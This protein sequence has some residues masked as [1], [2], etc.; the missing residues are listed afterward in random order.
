MSTALGQ[1]TIHRCTHFID[2][3]CGR[4]FDDP[5]GPDGDPNTW[6]DNDYHLSPNSPCIDAGDPN[7][8]A[9]P[10]WPFDI[11]GE[12]RVRDGR[13]DMGSDEYWADHVVLTL[14]VDGQNKGDVDL[15]PAPTDSID[16]RHWY[17]IDT[18]VTLTAEP[19]ENK[20]WGG[21]QGD[22]DPNDAFTNPLT[23]VMDSDKEIT[24]SF[25][26]GLGVGPILPMMLGV[27]GVFALTRRR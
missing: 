25:R 6:E 15:D 9:D 11:D 7:F 4:P 3:S 23:I 19:D 16:A 21:W 1:R 13:V 26:C 17:L 24:T 18:S 27:L 22:V 5:N 10:N 12:P 20:Y 14:A 2:S 8:V